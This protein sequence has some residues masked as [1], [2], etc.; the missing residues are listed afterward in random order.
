MLRDWEWSW[1]W[2][3]WLVLA[4]MAGIE[5]VREGWSGW[6]WWTTGMADAGVGIETAG[7]AG[8]WGTTGMLLL[9][10]LG[11]AG[12]EIARKWLGNELWLGLGLG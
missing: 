3:E 7:G 12:V 9:R 5:T 8:S 10:W 4:W 2:H 11:E 6:D 1:H